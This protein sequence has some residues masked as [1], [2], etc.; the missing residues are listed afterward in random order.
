M[1]YPS[2][3]TENKELKE[4][5][6]MVITAQKNSHKWI[7][8]EAVDSDETRVTSLIGCL[9]SSWNRQ[10]WQIGRSGPA[11]SVGF[12]LHS[13]CVF[14]ISWTFQELTQI[15]ALLGF[16]LMKRTATYTQ[17]AYG[18][19]LVKTVI[20]RYCLSEYNNATVKTKNKAERSIILIHQLT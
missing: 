8:G 14:P 12:P 2:Y 17:L 9:C 5:Y 20:S 18:D 13:C 7:N 16:H 15:A 3:F 6:K 10:E 4:S 1:L 19:R 11:V